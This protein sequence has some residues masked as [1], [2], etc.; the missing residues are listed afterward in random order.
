MDYSGVWFRKTKY[1]RP[2]AD[3]FLDLSR[4]TK[5]LKVIFDVGGNI[6]QTVGL[7][8]QA[9]PKSVIYSFEP[10]AET[11]K[12]LERNTLT[13]TNVHCKNI[14]LGSERAEIEIILNDNPTSGTNT[15]NPD[16]MNKR[17]DA[18]REVIQVETLDSFAE[19]ENLKHINMLK[20]DTEGWELNVLKGANNFIKNGAI[21]FLLCEVG[22]SPENK[23]NTYFPE[24]NEYLI[25]YGYSVFALYDYGHKRIKS[26]DHYANALFINRNLK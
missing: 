25:Q 13:F 18:K 10:V 11:F 2:G 7:F 12:E 17:P 15:L 6:G 23:L 1:M 8:K 22:F 24:L 16:R 4:N 19:S 9:Y 14:A 26:G 21:D 3:M 5:D 20:I